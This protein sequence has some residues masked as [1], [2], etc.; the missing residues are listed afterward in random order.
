MVDWVGMQGFP[1]ESRLTMERRFRYCPAMLGEIVIRPAAASEAD[2]LLDVMR[3]AFAE[4]RGV[5][6]P[7][8]SVFVE[9]AAL[10]AEKLGAGGGF[11]ALE[12]EKPVGCIIAE[13]KSGHGYLGRL[14]V[15]PALRRHGLARR[16]M[17]TGEGFVRD[18]GLKSVELQVRIV[19]TGNITLF[20]SLGYRETA[21][22]CHPGY[23]LP[24]YLVMEKSLE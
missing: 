23:A 16:L 14:A 18:R 11:L 13:A 6:K 19:L 8:S 21:Q 17:Q 12:K 1:P 3:R 7:E 15:D 4:Y 22:A 10:I 9:T 24:T 2:V 5:L 20:Q